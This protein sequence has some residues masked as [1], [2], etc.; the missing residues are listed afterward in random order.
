MGLLLH[1][2]FFTY[3]YLRWFWNL[4][5][6]R[7]WLSCSWL[8]AWYKGVTA[9]VLLKQMTTAYLHRLYKCLDSNYLLT[10]PDSSASLTSSIIYCFFFF[11]NLVA[12]G[13][14]RK[15]IEKR[16]CILNLL[17]GMP[18][19]YGEENVFRRRMDSIVW[20]YRRAAMTQIITLYNCSEQQRTSTSNSWGEW[21]MVP[22]MSARNLRLH[23]IK[24]QLEV[25]KL[26]KGNLFFF[27]TYFI[28]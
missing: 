2:E 28:N 16:K 12:S 27:T 8:S 19:L 26:V 3:L 14:C 4:E 10:T 11:V 22:L 25:W 9:Q 17:F 5:W 18:T 7:I 23:W 13:V 1:S 24:T 21:A 15:T 6:F 20:A